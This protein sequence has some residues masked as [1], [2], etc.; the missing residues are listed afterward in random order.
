MTQV[1]DLS[2]RINTDTICCYKTEGDTDVG[3]GRVVATRG[4][5]LLMRDMF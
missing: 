4:F 1:F 2:A 3:C 5:I